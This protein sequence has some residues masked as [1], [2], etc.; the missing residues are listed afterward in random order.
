[1]SKKYTCHIVS[2]KGISG[3]KSKLTLDLGAIENEIIDYIK[4]YKIKNPA[5]MGHSAGGYVTLKTVLSYP[6]VFSRIILVDSYPC[7]MA[8][9]MPTVTDQ[10]LKVQSENF[11][12]YISAMD[13]D[14]D[15]FSDKVL[16][17]LYR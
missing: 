15:W 5:I 13:D 14:K 17:F 7:I 16:T 8:M 9:S 10:I 3:E 6:G 11:K 12:R 4:V 2:I 1:M